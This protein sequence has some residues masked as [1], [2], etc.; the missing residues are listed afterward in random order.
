MVLSRIIYFES[1]N[2]KSLANTFDA[3][4]FALYNK[5]IQ[6]INKK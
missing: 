5:Y 4:S 3:S 6:P 1:K 2:L